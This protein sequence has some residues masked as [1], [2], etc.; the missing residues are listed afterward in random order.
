MLLARILRQNLLTGS[1]YKIMISRPFTPL[2]VAALFAIS[3]IAFAAGDDLKEINRLYQQ[4]QTSQ[5][6]EQVNAYLASKPKDAQAR[7]IKGVILTDQKKTEEAIKVFTELTEEYPELPEPYNNLAVLYASL[8]Q[9]ERAK[10]ALELAIRTHPSY[11]T[12]HE[13]LGD[14]YA[15]LA[16]RAYDKALQLDVTNT[17]AQTKLAMIKDL[18]GPKATR[19]NNAVVAT[20]KPAPSKSVEPPKP[21]TV[22]TV[23]EEP[24]KSAPPSKRVD[25]S[26]NADSGEIVGAVEAWAK[27]W[28]DKNVQRYLSAYAPNFQ[29]PKG[30]SR[31]S[32]ESERKKR[33]QSAKFIKVNVSQAKVSMSGD[34]EATVVFHQSYQSN[35]L[36]S[37]GK[38]TLHLVRIDGKWL[39]KSEK[40]RG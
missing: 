32:W 6:L 36:K 39:I 16:S 40:N 24:V 3:G 35:T 9:Y 4:G 33:L 17:T 28:S 37:S 19:A 13:N 18:F 27:A 7:F 26:A 15:Q 12:A 29:P 38:K 23:V 5:A 31:E 20:A 2:L 1:E 25:T 21:A 10:I 14:I 22:A 11:A 34:D 8:G 30:E